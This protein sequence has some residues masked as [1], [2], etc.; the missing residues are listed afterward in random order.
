M[1]LTGQIAGAVTKRAVFRAPGATAA[2]RRL[3]VGYGTDA[4]YVRP[5]GVSIASLAEANPGLDL[6]VHV[7]A[8]SITDGDLARLRTLAEARPGLEIVLYDVDAA[9]FGNLP[10]LRRYPLAIYFRLLMPLVLPELERLLYLDSDILCLGDLG[11]LADAAPEGEVAAVVSDVGKTPGNRMAALGMTGGRYFNSGV[12]LIRVPLWNSLQVSERTLHLLEE[13]PGR[14]LLPDQDALN[15]L[16][17]GR[18]RYLPSAWNCMSLAPADVAS[19]V[20]LHCA[21]HPKPWRAACGTP[22]QGLYLGIEARTPW[23][24]LPLEPPKDYQ[25][26]RWFAR[27]L[28][29]T[30]EV[31]QGL[32]WFARSGLMKFRRKVLGRGDA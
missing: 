25:E 13:T 31:S 32:A 28:F 4:A 6:R 7:F 24:G 3:D 29:R 17:E 1:E 15:V 20:L 22:A 19:A 5:M 27:K 11:P 23:G 26:A 16:L 21:A 18:L 8:S 2:S 12:M 30:G 9:V 14:F 10:I